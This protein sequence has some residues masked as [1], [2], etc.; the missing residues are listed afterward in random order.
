[1]HSSWLFGNLRDFGVSSEQWRS[2]A[3]QPLVG[4]W[5]KGGGS[6]S[7]GGV[8]VFK[9]VEEIYRN[10]TTEKVQEVILQSRFH[11]HI[12]FFPLYL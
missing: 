10:K 4:H 9:L 3:S 6:I 8:G 11:L 5:H 12:P 7:M 2:V 1:M